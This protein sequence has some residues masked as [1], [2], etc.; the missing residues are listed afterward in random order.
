MNQVSSTVANTRSLSS[1]QQQSDSWTCRVI[2]LFDSRSSLECGLGTSLE[3]VCHVIVSS[4]G[5]E[6]ACR[7]LE[8]W[9]LEG[10]SETPQKCWSHGC[11]ED[12]RLWFETFAARF[13][14]GILVQG[15]CLAGRGRWRCFG[16]CISTQLL[17]AE[18]WQPVVG[19]MGWKHGQHCGVF[20]C[21]IT[22]ARELAQEP[23][24]GG[25]GRHAFGS[26][27]G[28]DEAWPFD[29][30]T[31]AA[32]RASTRDVLWRAGRGM[33]SLL[34]R[35]WKLFVEERE[36][37]CQRRKCLVH[38]SRFQRWDVAEAEDW[39]VASPVTSGVPFVCSECEWRVRSHSHIHRGAHNH[40]MY[41]ATIVE[42]IV[43]V[44]KDRFVERYDVHCYDT[45]GDCRDERG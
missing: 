3:L 19:R 37:V 21:G 27:R 33:G 20:L 1:S 40:K 13:V 8:K 31:D 25:L 11:C 34:C 44:K 32:S 38:A 29:V 7:S 18:Q 16:G 15:I 4:S 10:D 41:I 9:D 6:W 30:F 5:C 28:S 24:A 43:E 35:C 2:W 26:F 22:A 23:F 12:V 45:W 42:K 17:R 14:R 36:I 39:V